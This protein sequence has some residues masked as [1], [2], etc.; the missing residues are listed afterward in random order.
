[1][2]FNRLNQNV[3]Q[4]ISEFIPTHELPQV[5]KNIAVVDKHTEE[6]FNEHV[7]R[8][9]FFRKNR[10]IKDFN[11]LI[12]YFEHHQKIVEK[13]L[14]QQIFKDKWYAVLQSPLLSTEQAIAVLRVWP[15]QDNEYVPSHFL[16]YFLRLILKVYHY[17]IDVIRPLFLRFHP[18]PAGPADELPPM[19]YHEAQDLAE[20]QTRLE[21]EN[22]QKSIK[23]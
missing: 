3:I 21:R 19:S 14:H 6:A 12:N 5:I 2:V 4:T 18:A 9:F 10:H 17:L 16:T 7:L 13:L 20:N 23:K 8:N 11:Q 22:I 1:M 15:R